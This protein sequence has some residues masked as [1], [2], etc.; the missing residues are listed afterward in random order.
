MF[1]KLMYSDSK[2][3]CGAWPVQ[4]HAYGYLPRFRASPVFCS[5][6]LYCSVED[7]GVSEWLAQ[8]CI[9]W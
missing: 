9:Q 8:C 1:S 5:I 4:R 7:K 6:K 2:C 3:K